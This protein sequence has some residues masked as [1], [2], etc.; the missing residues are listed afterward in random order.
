MVL[1]LILPPITY[2]M[3]TLCSGIVIKG[4]ID[5]GTRVV[6]NNYQ[7][8]VKLALCSSIMLPWTFQLRQMITSPSLS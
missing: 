4:F 6:D 2:A 7:G 8:E 3:I 1:A 5:V